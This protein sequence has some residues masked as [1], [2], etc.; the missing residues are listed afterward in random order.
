MAG[1]SILLDTPPFPGPD[2]SDA[3]RIQAET[4]AAP[5]A[6]IGSG[7]VSVVRPELGL[8]AT[9]PV[10]DRLVLRMLTR[11]AESRYRFRG[12]VWGS[13]VLFPF[14]AGPDADQ[15]IGE[16]LDLHAARLALE[17]AYRLSD[18]TNW[19]ADGEQWAVLGSTNV[20][21]RWEDGAFD[22]GLAAGGALGLGYEIPKLLRVALGVSLRTSLDKAELD[23]GPVLLAALEADRARHRAHARARPPGR[24]RSQPRPSSSTLPASA[25]VTAYRLRDRIR[26]L[27]DLS[28]RDRQ[29]RL[30]V[31]FDWS[32]V[33]LAAHRPRGRRH[34]R[35][36]PAR[37]R[38]GSRDA[39]VA[40]RRFLGLLRSPPRSAAVNGRAGARG[41][42]GA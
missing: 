24:G 15:L 40:P 29:V 13:T 6:S 17:G 5:D 42:L 36:A 16:R 2:V 30:G 37:A 31:G 23:P 33:R 11:V 21:S 25:R 14:G 9:W 34:R 8:R 3:F 35:P 1:D 4:F 39:A 10:S 28:F 19:F 7:H 12:D 26:P 32:L 22:S 20:G 18:D 27:G 41:M 38:G